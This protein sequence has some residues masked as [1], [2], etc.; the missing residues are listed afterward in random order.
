MRTGLRDHRGGR[1]LLARVVSH[2]A[3][4]AA[5]GVLPSALPAV[6]P[7]LAQS[8]TAPQRPAVAVE[9]AASVAGG[10]ARMVFTVPDGTRADVRASSGVLVIRFDR[11]VTLDAAALAT[12][13]PGYASAVRRDPDGTS[14]RIALSQRVTVNTMEA[15]ERIFVDLMPDSWRGPA[16]GLPADVV[17]ELTRRARDAER[18][19]RV[20]EQQR[21]ARAFPPVVVRIGNHP[22]FTRFVFPLPEPVAVALDRSQERLTVRIDKPFPADLGQARAG[23]PS[24]I[25][26]IMAETTGE[27]L[28]VRFLLPQNA[29]VRGFRDENTYVVDV[30]HRNGA[31]SA[32]S[33]P[34]AG[35]VSNEPVV[36]LPGGQPQATSLPV[37][38][39]AAAAPPAARPA[40]SSSPATAPVPASPRASDIVTPPAAPAPAAAPQTGPQNAP[41]PSVPRRPVVAAGEPA[42]PPAQAP[43]P[44]ETAVPQPAPPVRGTSDGPVQVQVRRVG[45][46]IRVLLPFG[47]DVPGAVF[48]RGDTLWLVFDA[49]QPLDVAALQAEAAAAFTS[50]DATRTQAG[51]SIRIGLDKPRLAT[52][53]RDGA[54]WIVTLSEAM[55]DPP[56]PVSLMRR[57]EP[58][59]RAVA[60]AELAQAGTVHRLTDPLAGD[61]LMVVT[62]R[63]PSRAFVR[64]QNFLEFHALPGSHGLVVHPVADDL[65]VTID[66]ESVVIGRPRG[67]IVTS[68]PQGAQ[69]PPRTARRNR[70][71]PFDLELWAADERAPHRERAAHLTAEAA[72]AHETQ[73]TQARMSLV[74][75]LMAKA[76]WPEAKAVV[77]A[78]ARDD[79]RIADDGMI[80]GFRGIAALMM[81]RPDEALREFSHPSLASAPDAALWR[82]A[83]LAR[84]GRAGE[85]LE[86]AEGHGVHGLPAPLAREILSALV[87]AALDSDQPA[88]AAT[89]LGQLEELGIGSGGDQALF[90]Q[91]GRVAEAQGRL[92]DAAQAYRRAGAGPDL[93]AAADGAQRL[94][95]LRH[96]NREIEPAA[97]LDLMDAMRFAW[98]GDGAEARNLSALA[99]LQADKGRYR[100]AFTTMRT[101]L[102]AYPRN[103]HVAQMHD[104]MA[105]RFADLFIGGGA[106]RMT[107]V[108]AL[109]LFY[110]F[111]ELTPQGRQGDELIR[112]LA[113]RLV[114]VDLLDQAASLL[115]H[116]VERRLTGAPRA[117]VAARLAVIQ[118]MNRKPQAALQVLRASRLPDLPESLRQQRYLLEARA[119]SDMGRTDQA[120]ELAG[121]VRTAEG[122]AL[123]ADILWS[124]ERYKDSAEQTERFLGQRRTGTPLSENERRQVLRAA[125]AHAL[126]D[127]GLSL[128]RIRTSWRALMAQTPD[129]RTFDILT[130]PIEARGVEYREI[131]RSIADLDTLQAFLKTYRERYP[132]E[133]PGGT[134]PPPARS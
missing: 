84:G 63:G 57:V 12:K 102:K 109:A 7:A 99:R 50:V 8:P 133:V 51:T 105:R 9:T 24:F 78:I 121:E 77:D 18:R 5:L 96:R 69:A 27:A 120:L 72:E 35:V 129:A 108:E 124:A 101:A 89:L 128:D 125:I 56:R 80:H 127:D 111:R 114:G 42:R 81:K 21:A 47:R 29:D 87:D 94:L 134:S 119:L 100:D 60:V 91:R 55:L 117:Q 11:P 106:D 79:Q 3:L 15:G 104:D 10:H 71:A 67:L 2:V 118:L 1:R 38:P 6:A 88:T 59:G 86:M 98:R 37:P 97:A 22:T 33:G 132:T 73:R 83:A 13:L 34:R 64:P 4:A 82:A 14:V 95:A 52:T 76:Y 36:T 19:A 130:A 49:G 116:Q 74:R 32:P 126:G 58:D 39:S 43:Q 103:P 48:Q 61:D 123:K 54:A 66:G 53:T 107:P 28:L 93:A 46:T 113:D 90:V 16:P 17:E 45:D 40:A 112:R 26:E 85:A 31:V 131:A 23:L 30:T 20:A 70:L 75:F 122:E 44:V 110:D 92:S 68:A 115:Q 25:P 62:A 41:A 65:Q